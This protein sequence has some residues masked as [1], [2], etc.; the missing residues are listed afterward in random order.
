MGVEHG[1]M[2][3]S[4][5]LKIKH[6]KR[7]TNILQQWKFMWN[8]ACRFPFNGLKLLLHVPRS[9]HDNGSVAMEANPILVT[10][11]SPKNGFTWFFPWT[12]EEKITTNI[13]KTYK[14]WNNLE[15]TSKHHLFS[16]NSA[17]QGKWN[18]KNWELWVFFFS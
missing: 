11:G 7:I 15:S 3:G 9:Y 12:L 18:V 10:L 13:W 8:P 17:L 16:Y 2:H 1:F 6:G 4:R 14:Q 5:E